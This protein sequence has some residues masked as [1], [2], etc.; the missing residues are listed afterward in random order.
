MI[1]L[2]PDKIQVIFK[3]LTLPNLIHTTI[4]V[5][6]TKFSQI[7]QFMSI[8]ES[9]SGVIDVLRACSEY[10]IDLVKQMEEE[11][12]QD[13]LYSLESSHNSNPGLIK[14]ESSLPDNG[15]NDGVAQGIF[16]MAPV[17]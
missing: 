16:Y 1:T 13:D 12:L 10:G 3:C 4:Y 6:S 2:L 5:I 14:M 15:S 8:S 9:V 17:F 11:L 7:K